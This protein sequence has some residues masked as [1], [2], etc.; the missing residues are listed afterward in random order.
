[1][2]E[3]LTVLIEDDKDDVFFFQRAMQK[4]DWPGSLQILGDGAEA[5]AYLTGAHSRTDET[6]HPMPSLVIL[7]LNLPIKTGL[8]VLQAFRT[9]DPDHTT[10]VAVLTSSTSERD[11]R[12][13]YRLGANCYFNKP[14]RP[15]ELLELLTAL[16]AR[17]IEAVESR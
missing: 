9:C 11:V 4:I 17:W 8:D 2:K 1:M 16:K 7:D 14:S 3:F 12:E 10:P 5:I 6:Q 15:D 13:A